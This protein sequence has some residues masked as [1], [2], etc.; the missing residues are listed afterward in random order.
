[1]SS[2]G[3]GE[4]STS[5]STEDHVYTEIVQFI[6]HNGEIIKE[7]T[8]NKKSFLSCLSERN[9]F[10]KSG[11]DYS[12]IAIL[13]PQSS[14]KST[15]LNLLFKTKFAVMDSSHG[16]RQTTQGVWMGIANM[17]TAPET[18]LIL[19]VEGTDGRERGEDE[20]AF[21]RKTSLFSL[22]LSSVLIINMWV[23][24]IGR[25]NAANIS[26]LKTVFEL[27]LQLFQKKSNHKTLLLFIIR[28]HDG[29]TPLEQL[30]DTLLQDVT[31]VWTELSKPKDFVHSKATDFFDFEFT[32]L[33]HKVYCPEQFLEQAAQLKGRFLDSSAPDYIPKKQ[34]RHDIPSDGL[35]QYSNNVWETIKTN[36]DLDLPSQKEMLALFRCDEFVEASY[37]S[38]LAELKPVREK[39]ERG[40]LFEKYG[41]TGKRLLQQ[42]LE[43]YDIPASRYH[44]ETAAKKRS[45]L[46]DRAM[47]E[48]KTLFNKQMEKLYE[49]SIDFYKSLVQDTVANKKSDAPGAQLIPHFSVWSKSIKQ[50]TLEYYERFA[51]ESVVPG[52]SWDYQPDLDQLEEKI[53]KELEALRESQLNKLAKFMRDVVFQQINPQLIKL[54]EQAKD[55]MWR[56][57]AELLSESLSKNESDYRKRLE[58]FDVKEE[59]IEDTLVAF[60]SNAKDQLKAKMKERVEFLKLRMR[61]RFEETFSFDDKKLPRKWS[62]HDDIAKIFEEARFN[63]EKLIDLFSYMRLQE[64]EF[65]FTFFTKEDADESSSSSASS[66]SKTSVPSVIIQPSQ[67]IM[68][69]EQCVD[70]VDNFRLDT[71]TDYMNAL[72]DQAKASSSGGVPGYIILLLCILGFNEFIAVITNPLLLVLT[73]LVGSGAFVLHKLNMTGPFIDFASSLVVHV[74][75][76]I[77]DIIMQVEHLSQHHPESRDSS[78]KKKD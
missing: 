76:K 17:E 28:D 2:M 45:G 4:H 31:N 38:F 26:L 67:I 35:Y 19:D 34:Y 68:T 13:G 1:M 61:K 73:I 60:R 49:Q 54:T 25:Y 71:K 18:Y 59:D 69:Y 11:F 39:I 40:K 21:E 48:L 12:V 9:D 66:S 47:L 7:E 20:K 3:E 65:E 53:T 8:D 46:N 72:N 41:E 30:R 37:N 74:M 56:K 29:Q 15:L 64:E 57:I 44:E 77:K 50:Q 32:S 75:N 23:H 58:D 24:D 14:G 5:S 27:N 36:K 51:K 33:P 22:V 16:R 62:K 78:K 43:L 10:L 63:A 52:S 55:D 42:C 6:D 70:L